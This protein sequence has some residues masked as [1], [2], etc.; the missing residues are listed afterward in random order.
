MKKTQIIMGMP[1]TIEVIDEVSEEVID[2]I[3]DYFKSVDKQFSTYKPDSEISRINNGMP[4][5]EWSPAMKKVLDLCEET[6]ELTDGYFDVAHEGKIDPSG[7]V[8]GWSVYNA[9]KLLKKAGA[10]NFYIEAGGD[11]Q[12]SGI[13]ADGGKWQI[14]IRS[15]F[16]VEEIIKAV[17]LDNKG[18]ATSGT[19]IRGQHIYNPL[20]ENK[21]I[22]E[23][24]S[25]T[26]IADNVYEADRFATAAFAMGLRGINF[27]EDTPGLEG[28]M[29]DDRKIATFTE[30][31]NNFVTNNS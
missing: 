13:N 17:E 20:G 26:V 18:V 5:D 15:P 30:G 27:I 19:Y 1:I 24:K 25:L 6:K 3:F 12:V 23:V 31:F 10:N 21:E 11:I 22:T 9:S 2:G 29:V 16:N 7:L 8:K 28:Y 14:G 4:E